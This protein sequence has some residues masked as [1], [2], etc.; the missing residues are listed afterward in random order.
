MALNVYECMFLLDT[1]KVSGDVEGTAQQLVELLEKNGAE[2]LARRPWD[3]RR[4]AY[5]INK[6]RKGLYYLTYFRAEGDKIVTIEEDLKLN[7]AVLRTLILKID[8]KLVDLMLQ[9]AQDEHAVALQ[10]VHNDADDDLD[11]V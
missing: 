10:T 5:P 1:S 2:V 8:P 3:E 4:L 11:M 7:E 6:Q 9:M